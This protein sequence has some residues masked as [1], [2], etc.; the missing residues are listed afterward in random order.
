[1]MANKDNPV[2]SAN[3]TFNKAAE[4]VPP[5]AWFGVSAIF[6]YLGP[7]FAVLLFPAVGVLGVAWFRIA[8]AALIFAPFTKPWKTILYAVIVT[9][10][11]SI[12]WV[13]VNLFTWLALTLARGIVAW[14]TSPFGWWR[15][16][17]GDAAVAKLELLWPLGGANA[18]YRWPDS[19]DISWNEYI[20]VFF[21]AIYVLLVI[22]MMWSFLASFYF[23][24]CTAVYFLLRRDVDKTD[25]DDIY[26]DEEDNGG[27]D[28]SPPA[29]NSATVPVR[30][31]GIPLPVINASVSATTEGKSTAEDAD[32]G[33]ASSDAPDDDDTGPTDSNSS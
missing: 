8:S 22:A 33:T 7:A 1:M 20:S 24:G 9:V 10:Y 19:T 12:C 26:I 30:E 28:Q 27:Y 17:T 21:I 29:T 25:L 13:C 16:G 2:P 4:T 31:E 14:G 15:R 23:S 5:H 32:D 3:L 11:A 6:H 18:L